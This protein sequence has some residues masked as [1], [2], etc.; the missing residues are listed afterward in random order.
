VPFQQAPESSGRAADI[1][2]KVDAWLDDPAR[3][4]VSLL[5]LPAVA[6]GVPPIAA[7]LLSG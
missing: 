7:D 3:A 6:T 1:V 2:D 4:L 5:P